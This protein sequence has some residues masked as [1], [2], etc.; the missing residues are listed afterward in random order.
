MKILLWLVVL[1]L[2]KYNTYYVCVS[3]ILKLKTFKTTQMY[4]IKIVWWRRILIK[5]ITEYKTT[6]NRETVIQKFL[7]IITF[8]KIQK[9]QVNQ[10]LELLKIY[11]IKW[12]ISNGNIFMYDVFV[13]CW[14]RVNK[15]IIIEK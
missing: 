5:N 14:R 3:I 13:C 4:D 15:T 9:S 7:T 8:I 2:C 11:S 1:C 10:A 12:R 6:E